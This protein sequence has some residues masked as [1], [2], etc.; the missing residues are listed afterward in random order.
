MDDQ[1]FSELMNSYSQSRYDFNPNTLTKKEINQIKTLAREKRAD[2]GIAP[3]GKN[4]FDYIVSKEK[5]LY[6]EKQPF[7]NMD[8]DGLIFVPPK[9]R[10]IAFI[11]LNSNQPLLN[12]IFATAHEYYHFL[13]DIEMVSQNPHICS[14]SQLHKK[15]EQSASR[16]AAEFLLPDEALK[17]AIDDWLSSIESDDVDGA[18]ISEITTLCYNLTMKY[19]LP[20]KAVLY[21]LFEEGLIK[22]NHFKS[23]ISNYEF[24]KNT[25]VKAKSLYKRQI[26]ELLS[27]DN[28]YIREVMYEMMPNAFNSG[29]VSLDKLENDAKILLLE[30]DR[31]DV[32]IDTDEEEEANDELYQIKDQLNETLFENEDL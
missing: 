23:L 32:H 7:E 4:I 22:S 9:S 31:L 13:T 26:E 28:P 6:F 21:R 11:I 5:K 1:T 8:L 10:D 20:L 30:V 18:G 15:I 29:Y 25:F 3:I 12:Q 2:Y 27:N 24:I 14:L 17:I 19:C 16:F